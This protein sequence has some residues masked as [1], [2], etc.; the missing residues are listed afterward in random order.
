MSFKISNVTQNEANRECGILRSPF[1]VV[2]SAKTLDPSIPVTKV[3]LNGTYT[4]TL[5]NGTVGERKVITA[6][7]GSGTVTIAYNRGWGGSNTV[8]L[9]TVSDTVEFIATVEG[10]HNNN[11]ID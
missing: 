4:I 5:P 2:S 7:S 10:W 8:S 3:T 9:G 6:V 11:W 1:E